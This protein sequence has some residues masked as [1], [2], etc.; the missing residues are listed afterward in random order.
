MTSRQGTRCPWLS[1]AALSPR[2]SPPAAHGFLLDSSNANILAPRD[3]ANEVHILILGESWQ[4]NII[5]AMISRWLLYAQLEYGVVCM[6]L[7]SHFE[8]HSIDTAACCIGANIRIAFEA[9][10]RTSQ[11]ARRLP[12]VPLYSPRNDLLKTQLDVTDLNLVIQSST[13]SLAFPLLIS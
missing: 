2:A 12:S 6:F 7:A 3:I 4:T 9:A 5:D 8:D 1:S 10:N 13:V 11:Y